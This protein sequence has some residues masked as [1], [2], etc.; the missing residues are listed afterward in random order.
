M[1]PQ[2]TCSQ[3]RSVHSSL[4][5]TAIVLTFNESLHIRRCIENIRQVAEH[6]VVIDSGST[7][8]TVIIA[9]SLGATVL[10]NPWLNHATQFNWALDNAPL[11]GEWVMRLD[12]DEYL[13]ATAMTALSEAIRHAN[14][15]IKGF[16][17]RRPT[18]FLDQRIS[19]GGMAPWLLRVWRSGAARCEERWM[20]EHIV[21]TQG[22]VMR[23][24]AG[25]IVD[26]NLNSL[27]WWVEKH[28]RYASREA[29]D[30][31]ITRKTRE[32]AAVDLN[33]QA[34]MK[35]WLKTKVYAKLPLGVRPFLFWLYRIIFLGGFLD[36]RR[37]LMF[38]TMQGLW[39]RLLV[40]ARVMEVEHSMQK[41]GMDLTTAI[42]MRLGIDIQSSDNPL[43]PEKN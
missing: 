17:L 1:I 24:L 40:D 30:M 23:Q 29:V 15:E 9:E 32:P 11:H 16:E 26:H 37:G 18:T 21:L 3:D 7:D 2:E 13:D 14:E 12:A 5:L 33:R 6:I 19:H 4:R 20:D 38:H 22:G 35:R 39:Y 27:S 28:N 36:G 34:R 43:A 25:Y 10:H 41:Q 8:D 31:L 42:R